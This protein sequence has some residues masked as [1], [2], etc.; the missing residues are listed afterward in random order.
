[1]HEYRSSDHL[2]VG[3]VGGCC[4]GT[5][6]K[7]VEIVCIEHIAETAAKFGCVLNSVVRKASCIAFATNGRFEGPQRSID[8]S[9]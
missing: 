1:M 8:T 4:S 7:A 5:N 2:W 3:S 9:I 6:A